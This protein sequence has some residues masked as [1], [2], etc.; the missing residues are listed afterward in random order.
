MTGRSQG[1]MSCEEAE[2][3]SGSS[4][5]LLLLGQGPCCEPF[6]HQPP[7]SL[8]LAQDESGE[9]GTMGTTHRPAAPSAPR[10]RG[11]G[12]S[13]GQPPRLDLTCLSSPPAGAGAWL[14]PRT[15]IRQPWAVAASG[16]V[17]RTSGPFL[18]TRERAA[19][20]KAQQS[21]GSCGGCCSR[22]AREAPQ[23][24]AVAPHSPPLLSLS[25]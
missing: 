9:R 11:A 20:T 6:P 3:E 13:R 24:L 14:P 8:K 25:L 4:L 18:P 10:A 1:L 19:G 15:G 21:W 2:Q 22:E 23:A 7:P 12:A 17:S 16:H 5:T